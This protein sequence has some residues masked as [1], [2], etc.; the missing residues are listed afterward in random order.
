M[1]NKSTKSDVKEVKLLSNIDLISAAQAE[2][3]FLRLVNKHPALYST[4]VL[5]NA[6]H[7]YET[8]WLP[9][10]AEH[11]DFLP[12]PLDIEWI[13]H[14]HI[15]NPRVYV[16]DCEKIVN[17][18]ID[19]RPMMLIKEKL[20]KSK[21]LWHKKYPEVT[22][23]AI[24]STNS[25]PLLYS[26]P[27]QQ[28]STYDVVKAAQ[29]QRVF[30]Y[31]SS[32]P[33]FRDATFLRNA[34]SRYLTMLEIMRDNPKN[35]VVPCYDNDLIWHTHQLFV[36]YYQSDT[37][38]ILGRVLGHDDSTSDRTP[39]SQLES[40]TSATKKLWKNIGK[41]F[42]VPGGMY[43]GEP[44]VPDIQNSNDVFGIASKTFN[45]NLK[46]I[47]LHDV[48]NAE[49]NF[50]LKIVKIALPETSAKD[51][52]IFEN[53]EFKKDD[54]NVLVCQCLGE[55]LLETEKHKGIKIIYSDDTN[56]YSTI[57]TE[58]D[59]CS[60]NEKIQ[61][62]DLQ[63][64]EESKE[65]LKNGSLC[66]ENTII[67]NNDYT[68]LIK[69]LSR[70]VNKADHVK[71]V[72]S[73]ISVVSG[74]AVHQESVPCQYLEN[75]FHTDKTENV[76]TL[77]VIHCQEPSISVV[78]ILDKR[79]VA[80]ATSHT[81]GSFQ[82]PTPSQVADDQKCFVH[83]KAFERAMLIR[84]REGDWAILKSSW[85]GY[86]EGQDNAKTVPG[87]LK[88]SLFVLNGKDS[89]W[90][91]I[92]TSE[93]LIGFEWSIEGSTGCIDLESGTIKLSK[94]TKNIAEYVCL[95]CSIA[96]SFLLCHPRRA[97]TEVN[98]VVMPYAKIAD[99]EPSFD[100]DAMKLLVAVGLYSTTLPRWYHTTCKGDSMYQ[101]P[102]ECIRNCQSVF[103]GDFGYIYQKKDS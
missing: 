33:H 51:V 54:D 86:R 80:V 19:H 62:L 58:F 24:I 64:K 97:P 1:G 102:P 100:I 91:P 16:K 81:I 14:C 78:E 48:T 61:I 44:P 31:N 95:A 6:M 39:G 47:K 29:R 41:S 75:V 4:T 93:N 32:F 17:K 13:W 22:F 25:P 84:G 52:E 35:F 49:E 37:V 68:F 21:E 27:F 26:E 74:S 40:G 59:L 10:I 5:K 87:N 46:S 30:N 18:V 67:K 7:R 92:S 98:N 88:L 83:T 45:I 96:V 73:C 90:H 79:G 15:L 34:V 38:S 2:Y 57:L 28:K 55:F 77:R 69:E 85:V 70:V 3:D 66:C 42:G 76:F 43:R 65:L 23:D 12:A 82:L 89:V 36:T 72:V 94:C 60:S 103:W 101:F 9:L 11:D 56:V 63:L 53:L 50:H 8:Y 99:V 20:Q 71:N